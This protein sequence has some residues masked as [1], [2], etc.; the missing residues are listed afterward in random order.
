LGSY[1]HSSDNRIFV[2]YNDLSPYLVKALIATEDVRFAEHSGIDV[3]GLFR[4]IIKRG[5]LMQKRRWRKYYH[6]TISETALLA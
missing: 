2:T 5:I 6:P 4:A 3:I 1:A